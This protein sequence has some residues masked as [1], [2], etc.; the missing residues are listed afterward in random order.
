MEFPDIPDPDAAWEALLKSIF[1][2]ASI[3]VFLFLAIKWALAWYEAAQ[4][5]IKIGRSARSV[6]VR[7]FARLSATPAGNRWTGIVMTAAMLALQACWLA[8][9]FMVGS[10]LSM[11]VGLSAGGEVDI[12]KISL[13]EFLG[14]LHY[15][16][17]SGGYTGLCLLALIHSYRTVRTRDKNNGLAT[18]LALPAIPFALFGTLGAALILVDYLALVNVYSN[19][20]TTGQVVLAFVIGATAIAYYGACVAALNAP[21][22]I[23]RFWRQASRERDV[24]RP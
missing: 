14:M 4:S 20:F 12:S 2:P 1:G 16:W 17:L 13:G 23:A 6:M 24:P 3:V 18:V 10:V 5:A 11:G 19:V 15:D 8:L 9:A 22:L 21:I 7:V